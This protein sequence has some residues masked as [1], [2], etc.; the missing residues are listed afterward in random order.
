MKT[1]KKYY[2]TMTDSFMSGWGKAQNLQN[3]L[4][5]ICDSY[6]EACIVADNAEHRSDQ[7]YI[8]ICSNKP[9]YYRSTFGTDYT[10]NNYYVQ[11]KTKDE[12][13]SWYKENYFNKS[14]K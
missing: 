4:I 7:K 13:N 14:F 5:F 10:L 3:K 12:Y 6:E 11:I 9:S 2:V 1:N 8:N